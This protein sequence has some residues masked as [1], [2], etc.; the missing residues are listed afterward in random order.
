MVLER[1]VN[2]SRPMYQDEDDWSQPECHACLRIQLNK[3]KDVNNRL[4]WRQ[5]NLLGAY[6]RSRDGEL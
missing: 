4:Y 1:C 5:R 2:C 3:E 6:R